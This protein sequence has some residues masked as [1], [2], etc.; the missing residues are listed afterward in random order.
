MTMRGFRRALLRDRR[1]TMLIETAIVAPALVVM[2]IGAFEVSV[3]IAH[4]GKLQSTAEQAVEMAIA[5]SP[6]TEA[7]R[8]AIEQELEDSSGLPDDKVDL[9]FKFRCGV[10]TELTASQGTCDDEATSQYLVM[11]LKDSYT[12][13]WTHWGFGEAFNYTETRSVQ[14]S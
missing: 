4:Q 3:M 2:C 12:P 11:T 10:G 7:E 5:S 14:V 8:S 9:V 6:E 1:G 13:V